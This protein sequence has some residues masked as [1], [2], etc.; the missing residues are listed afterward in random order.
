MCKTLKLR[1]KDDKLSITRNRNG[2]DKSTASFDCVFKAINTNGIYLDEFKVNGVL[3]RRYKALLNQ[4]TPTLYNDLNIKF[5]VD[6]PESMRSI[7][8][9]QR[10]VKGYVSVYVQFTL[11][12]SRIELDELVFNLLEDY[13]EE[14][15]NNEFFRLQQRTIRNYLSVQ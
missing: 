2:S 1:S 7:E 12:G 11:K 6:I 13:L 5:I 15:L 3:R 4:Y 9:S 14:I 10:R 8:P